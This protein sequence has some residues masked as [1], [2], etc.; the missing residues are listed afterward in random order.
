M[1]DLKCVSSLYT[2]VCVM[3]VFEGG[4]VHDDKATS[5][6]CSMATP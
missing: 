1:K 6:R 5:R 2:E 4:S 3:S